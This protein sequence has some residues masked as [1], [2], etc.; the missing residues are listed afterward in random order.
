MLRRSFLAACAAMTYGVCAI[1]SMA[2]VPAMTAKLA[3]SKPLGRPRYFVQLLLAGGMDAVYTIDP[4]RAA[5]VDSW[6]DVP[7]AAK[8]IVATKTG[9]LGP[10]FATLLREPEDSDG[11]IIAAIHEDIAILYEDG[12]ILPHL[13]GITGRCSD[14]PR[15]ADRN[16]HT[17]RQVICQ[18]PRVRVLGEMAASNGHAL[19]LGDLDLTERTDGRSRL[20][21]GRVDQASDG[22]GE[23]VEKPSVVAVRQ[24]GTAASGRTSDERHVNRH[25]ASE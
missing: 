22:V 1:R 14:R 20:C 16:P 21:G 3:S 19:L 9:F 24:G 6:V 13:R 10:A 5:D 18:Y 7:Y 25:C 2:S 4:K 8:E 12:S 23:S 15:V 17:S 11:R